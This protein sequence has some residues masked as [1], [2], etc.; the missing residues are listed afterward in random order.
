MA[1]SEQLKMARLAAK[2]ARRARET[3]LLITLLSSPAVQVVGTIALAEVLEQNG[4]ISS[5]GAGIIE[6]GVIGMVGLQ[7]AEKAG[8]AGLLAVGGGAGIGGLLGAGSGILPSTEG[9]QNAPG[10]STS[11]PFTWFRALSSLFG[12]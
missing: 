12:G 1:A 8:L 9:W 5:A 6:G 4:I 2:E 3:Q 7:A 11:N 10:I